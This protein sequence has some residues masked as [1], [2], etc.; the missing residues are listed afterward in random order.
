M[1]QKEIVKSVKGEAE[2]EKP[3]PLSGEMRPGIISWDRNAP[4]TPNDACASGV[5]LYF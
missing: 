2:F 1:M 3:S 4:K 5:Y